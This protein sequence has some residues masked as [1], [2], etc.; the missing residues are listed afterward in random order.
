MD[1]VT[2][3]KQMVQCEIM[4]DSGH[5]VEDSSGHSDRNSREGSYNNHTSLKQEMV[6]GTIC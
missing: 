6:L 3:N 4:T 5:I 1:I 2:Q